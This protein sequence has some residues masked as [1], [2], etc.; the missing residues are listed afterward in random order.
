M[1][2]R[3]LSDLHIDLN[4]SYTLRLENKDDFVLIAGDISGDPKITEKWLNQNVKNGI[5]IAGNH[6]VYNKKK[7]TI[8]ELKQ[9]LANKFILNSNITFLDS[10]IGIIS[11]EVN[12]ILFVGTTLYTD[13]NLNNSAEFDMRVAENFMNDFRWGIYSKNKDFPEDRLVPEFTRLAPEHYLEY[14]NKSIQMMDKVLSENESGDQITKPVV[15]LTHHCPST[16]FISEKYK[17]SI[18]NASYVSNL[19]YFMEKHPSIKLW[20]SGHIHN[21]I[22]S[23]YVR[24]DGSIIKLVANPR[25]YVNQLEASDWTKNVY[26]D[27][28]TWEVYK[29]GKKLVKTTLI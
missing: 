9:Y 2:I 5:F 7:Q 29:T 1:K 8:L 4:A 25:G 19:E 14:F 28:D 21:R 17:E 15:I 20:L 12:G 18:Y 24:Q 26:V 6:I 22:F 11:K 10:E 27:T 13:Y 3:L 23:E 16:K